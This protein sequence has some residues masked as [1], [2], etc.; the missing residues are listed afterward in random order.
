M[1]DKI[2]GSLSE[3][4]SVIS[5]T[6]TGTVVDFAVKRAIDDSMNSI[7]DFLSNT[8][9]E[10]VF[11]MAIENRMINEESVEDHRKRLQKVVGM[12]KE[13]NI[14]N[15]SSKEKV[16]QAIASLKLED[17]IKMLLERAND[18]ELYGNSRPMLCMGTIINSPICIRWLNDNLEKVKE[19][20]VKE[21]ER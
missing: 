15:E 8:N 6:L 12:A 14:L 2:R 17:V 20:V 21:I 10:D 5:E 18:E 11:K 7:I 13:A 16:K 19:M 9:P 1:W 4:R 3:Y